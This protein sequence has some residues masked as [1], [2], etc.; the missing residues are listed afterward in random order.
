VAASEHSEAAEEQVMAAVQ[1]LTAAQ[2]AAV[3]QLAVQPA[4]K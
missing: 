3:Q 2:V 1:Q 4:H